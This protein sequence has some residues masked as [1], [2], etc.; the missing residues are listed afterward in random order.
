MFP[1]DFFKPF[2]WPLSCVDQKLSGDFLAGAEPN[3]MGYIV[4]DLVPPYND[5]NVFS[6]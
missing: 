2:L 1:V 5:G 6:W 3:W 4:C